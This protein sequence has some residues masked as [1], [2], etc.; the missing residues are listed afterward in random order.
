MVRLDVLVAD[1]LANARRAME[2]KAGRADIKAAR[3]S[4]VAR[5]E[6]AAR[7]NDLGC[8]SAFTRPALHRRGDQPRDTRRPS[9][10]LGK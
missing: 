5:R 7:G 3:A 1:V 8:G 4:K 10:G 6:E 9:G 2:E